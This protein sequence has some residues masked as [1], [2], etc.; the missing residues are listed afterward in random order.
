VRK[1]SLWRVCRIPVISLLMIHWESFTWEA[2]ATLV[3]GLAAVIAATVVARRQSRIIER[4]VILQELAFRSDVFDRRVEVYNAIHRYVGE[5]VFSGNHEPP[6]LDMFAEY[7][8]AIE[9]SRFLFSNRLHLELKALR[10]FVDDFLSH[11]GYANERRNFNEVAGW[12]TA[13]A[14]LDRRA[15]ELRRRFQALPSLF[16]PELS[17]KVPQASIDAYVTSTNDDDTPDEIGYI[18]PK[19]RRP[20]R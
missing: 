7:F 20:E 6:H 8:D 5:I 10:A 14:E 17:L 16:E 3:T 4:Q 11:A 12:E 19:N 9:T 15:I 2:F 1:I 18:A 13:R